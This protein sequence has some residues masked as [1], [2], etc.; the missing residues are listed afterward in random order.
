MNEAD[1]GPLPRIFS[2][3]PQYARG[4]PTRTRTHEAPQCK[5][6]RGFRRPRR[7]SR[8][9]TGPTMMVVLLSGKGLSVISIV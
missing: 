2:Y 9:W 4:A 7:G 1:A 5:T 3:R 6:L 8:Y